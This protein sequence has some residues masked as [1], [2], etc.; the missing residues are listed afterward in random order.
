MDVNAIREAML[1]AVRVQKPV[2]SKPVVTT[3]SE[4]LMPKGIYE[5]PKCD[6]VI[7]VHLAVFSI[8]C[9]RHRDGSVKMVRKGGQ[10]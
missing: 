9:M 2:P 4:T 8:E 1:E 5:C 3:R 10:K 6:N 7:Q